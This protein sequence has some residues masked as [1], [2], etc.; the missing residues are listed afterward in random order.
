MRV[1]FPDTIGGHLGRVSVAYY[2]TGR[3]YLHGISDILKLLTRDM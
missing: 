2:E 1:T 3:P